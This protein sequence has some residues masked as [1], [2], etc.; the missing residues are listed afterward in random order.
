MQN[1]LGGVK[2]TN[3][4]QTGNPIAWFARMAICLCSFGFVYPNAM[5]EGIDIAALDAEIERRAKER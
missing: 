5:I 4:A 1:T 2:S 3:T